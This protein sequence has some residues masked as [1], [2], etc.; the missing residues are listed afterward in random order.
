MKQEPTEQTWRQHVSRLRRNPRPS[1]RGGCQPPA[2]GPNLSLV[3]ACGPAH[4]RANC[5]ILV[6]LITRFRGSGAP[7]P[8]TTWV[9]IWWLFCPWPDLFSGGAQ[10]WFMPSREPSRGLFWGPARGC[11]L[12]S[13]GAFHDLFCSISDPFGG[14]RA[15]SCVQ[16]RAGFRVFSRL[17]Q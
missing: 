16:F 15:V 10:G 12:A 5:L 4:H 8:V 6:M 17:G 7:R 9:S 1:G 3:H 11:F 13:A 14:E 2:R